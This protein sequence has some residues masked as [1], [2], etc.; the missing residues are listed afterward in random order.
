MAEPV[1]ELGILSIVLQKILAYD[2]WVDAE[3]ANGF[4]K[5][6]IQYGTRS[7]NELPSGF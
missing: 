2:E 3:R 1:F 6:V 5:E 7:A 4:F